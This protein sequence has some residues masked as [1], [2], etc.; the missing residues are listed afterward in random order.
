MFDRTWNMPLYYKR[1]K[2]ETPLQ[3]LGH[4]EATLKY[5][6]HFM[7]M[8]LESINFTLEKLSRTQMLN[9]VN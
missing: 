3:V 5:L 2:R 9:K 6:P 4:W 1:E 8:E 7:F